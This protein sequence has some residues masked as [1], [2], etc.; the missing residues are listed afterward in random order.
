LKDRRVD[1]H[2]H[3]TAS[4]GR[5]TPPS[6]IEALQETGIS[7]FAVTDHDSVG[8]VAVAEALAREAG[9]AFLRGVE[10]STKVDGRLMHVLAYGYDPDHAPLIDF[11]QQNEARLQ[12]YDD[13]LLQRLVD[14][15]YDLDLA[16]YQAYTWD[17]RRGGWK[18]LNYLIDQGLCRDV[19]SFFNELFVGELEADFPDFPTPEEAIPLIREGG[20]VP[21][22]AH[23]ATSLSRDRRYRP[24]EDETVV[25][26]MVGWGIEGLECYTCHHD[27]AWTG[28]LVAWARQYDLLV[29][30]G[31]DSHG[32]FAG[33]HLGRP[34]IALQQLRLGPLMERIID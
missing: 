12:A 34:D 2:I 28:R 29:T 1:L 16:H 23:P 10:I 7:L 21:V 17:R 22:W 18:S 9:L 26:R 25:A 3:T 32:G 30:G 33:R 4:D 20:G 31:S 14:A 27:D 6:L 13:E 5:W 15:G 8:S 19:H 24:E 11:I